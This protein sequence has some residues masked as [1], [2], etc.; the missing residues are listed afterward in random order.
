M[1]LVV[2]NRKNV[3]FLEKK[4]IMISPILLADWADADELP[5]LLHR[6]HTHANISNNVSNSRYGNSGQF[7][8]SYT[9]LN[10]DK[11][12]SWYS[13][14]VSS[15]ISDCRT[16]LSHSSSQVMKEYLI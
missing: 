1:L 4:N 14:D 10:S 11:H 7:L 8:S 5:K 13:D 9:S 16:E 12:H 3:L 2:S 6:D 15:S